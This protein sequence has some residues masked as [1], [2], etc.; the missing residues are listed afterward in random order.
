MRIFTRKVLIATA[1]GIGTA[2]SLATG[3]ITA[4]T[5]AHAA[6]TSKRWTC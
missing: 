2:G 6:P 3:L 1:L 5:P 4:S